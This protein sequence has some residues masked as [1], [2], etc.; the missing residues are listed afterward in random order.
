[1]R[2]TGLEVA[3]TKRRCGAVDI[4]ELRNCLR[5]GLVEI[6]AAAAEELGAQIVR[7][8]PLALLTHESPRVTRRR[9]GVIRRSPVSVETKR[10]VGFRLART[11]EP[12]LFALAVTRRPHQCGDC[13]SCWSPFLQRSKPLPDLVVERTLHMARDDGVP[14]VQYCVRVRHRRTL[15]ARGRAEYRAR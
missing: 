14:S 15:F 4:A 6:P 11:F 12:Q 9:S 10:A 5:H 3:G 2:R 1:M 7:M 8:E 13:E